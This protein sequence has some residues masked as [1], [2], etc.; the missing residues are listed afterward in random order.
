MKKTVKIMSVLLVLMF[1]MTIVANIALAA[2]PAADTGGL[3][4]VISAP[5]DTAASNLKTAGGKIIGYVQIVGAVVAILMVVVIGVKY[6]AASSEGKAEYKK[7]MIPYLVGAVL[8]FAG[9]QIAG[10]VYNFVTSTAT[11]M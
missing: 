8:V 3:G 9:S 11:G 10:M 1:A 6:I 2:E 4:I 7:N 5:T